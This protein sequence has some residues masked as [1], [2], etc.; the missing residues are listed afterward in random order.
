LIEISTLD[1]KVG[2]I[3][4]KKR[5]WKHKRLAKLRAESSFWQV[6]SAMQAV[7]LH[8]SGLQ[9]AFLST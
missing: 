9:M 2:Q 7:Q 5:I 8:L 3:S 4:G 6:L 1:L